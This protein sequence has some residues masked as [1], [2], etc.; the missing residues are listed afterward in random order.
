MKAQAAFQK[1]QQASPEA[2]LLVQ[3]KDGAWTMVEGIDFAAVDTIY[4]P[5]S[6][7]I[8]GV[9]YVREDAKKAEAA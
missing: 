6:I 2:R 4:A 1:M 9:R 3:G 7:L 5:T 8:A